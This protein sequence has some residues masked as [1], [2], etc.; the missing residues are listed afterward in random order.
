MEK[1]NWGVLGTA[2]IAKNRTIPGM[3]QAE[4]CHLYAIAGRKPEKVAAFQTQFGFEKAYCSYE[5]LLEDDQVQA[6]YI[7]LSNDLHK[8][9]ICKAAKKKKHILC[10][11]PLVPTREDAEQ[12]IRVCKEEGVLLMEAFAYL[13]SDITKALIA[14]ARG[15]VIGEPTLIE[16]CFF[17]PRMAEDNIRMR[18][19]T[20]GGCTYDLGCYNLSLI[21]QLM[22][23]SPKNIEALA[24]F[25]E[26][27]VEDYSTA[28]LE[29]SNHRFASAACG[30][31]ADMRE[32]QDSSRYFVYGTQGSIEA[33][34]PYNASGRLSY[35]ILKGE[36]S[37]EIELMVPNN[38]RLEV[39]QFNRCILQ[40]ERPLVSNAFSLQL[41]GV[42]D[43][44]L[45]KIG[46]PRK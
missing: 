22:G 12:V 3:Q 25:M 31:C 35:R 21:L 14:D 23:E 2:S 28:F 20:F 19:E 32:G 37:R 4:G 45:S 34:I 7:P 36:D 15:G 46:Y 24:H 39:E 1:V 5:E 33:N 42:M 16:A 26:S 41:A 38:Y 6:V 40:G 17:I 10:E 9:W 44:V 43:A 18:R 27:G 11:K 30:M 8:E 29:F 13:H